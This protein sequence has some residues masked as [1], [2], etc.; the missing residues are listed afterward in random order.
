M[1]TFSARTVGRLVDRA[2]DRLLLSF[3]RLLEQLGPTIGMSCDIWTSRSMDA[4][5]GVT[6]HF[7]DPD[8]FEFRRLGF[9]ADP[10]VQAAEGLL[11]VRSA[12]TIG[13]LDVHAVAHAFRFL[14]ARAVECVKCIHTYIVARFCTPT[15]CCVP[16][17]RLAE[18]SS[19]RASTE[20]ASASGGHRSGGHRAGAPPS[21]ES[22]DLFADSDTDEEG[23]RDLDS[24]F[25]KEWAAYQSTPF[26]STSTSKQWDPSWWVTHQDQFPH[27]A[28]AAR[29]VL[30]LPATGASSGRLFSC[31]GL[32]STPLRNRLK[33]DKLEKLTLLAS[34][35]PDEWQWDQWKQ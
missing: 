20:D 31:A 26:K 35:D 28:F 9:G 25:Q 1:P 34:N 33:A 24:M 2:Y 17:C 19:Q 12:C 3:T 4:F 6:A 32:V 13:F 10:K 5:V 14:H 7:V 18:L 30:C 23:A 21:F 22:D 15:S 29:K 8:T 16:T 27:I 11:Y